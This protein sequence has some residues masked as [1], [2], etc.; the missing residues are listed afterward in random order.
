MEVRVDYNSY[1]SRRFSKPWISKVVYWQEGG[2]PQIVFGSYIGD[3]M[4][5]YVSISAEIGDIIRHGQKDNRQPKN[6]IYDWFMVANN[7]LAKIDVR[8]ARDIFLRKQN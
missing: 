4:G 8:E 2:K 6:N 5:G 7:G 3:D 1:N